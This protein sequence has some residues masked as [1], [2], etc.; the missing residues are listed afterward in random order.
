M[1]LLFPTLSNNDVINFV[2]CTFSYIMANVDPMGSE[3]IYKLMKQLLT[4]DTADNLILVATC[5]HLY[6]SM[7][8]FLQ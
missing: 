3:E 6:G 7:C 2:G 4:A 8:A 5:M 1:V